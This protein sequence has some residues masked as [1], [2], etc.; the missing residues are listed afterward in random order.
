MRTQI[1]AKTAINESNITALQIDWG[2]QGYVI[3]PVVNGAYGTPY[4]GSGATEADAMA[5]G[6]TVA[7]VKAD[8]E[9]EYKTVAA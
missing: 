4:Y 5:V 8:G 3:Y 9:Y 1:S 6:D 2:V 7:S